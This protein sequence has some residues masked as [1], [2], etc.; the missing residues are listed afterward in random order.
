MQ[1]LLNILQQFT[2]L[3]SKRNGPPADQKVIQQKVQQ[4]S[5]LSSGTTGEQKSEMV[6]AEE[7]TSSNEVHQQGQ[8]QQTKQNEQPQK[9]EG[10]QKQE[11]QNR[12]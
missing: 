3:I 6:K 5:A 9:Q 1:A 7:S 8:Q 2:Q 10:E 12:E 11:Q 4:P